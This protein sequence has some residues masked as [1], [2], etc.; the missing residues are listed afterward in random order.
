[1]A[2][3]SSY[4]SH[5]AGAPADPPEPVH[6]RVLEMALRARARQA[7]AAVDTVAPWRDAY[8]IDQ[9]GAEADAANP[10]RNK[11]SDGTIGD[12]AHAA[13][14]KGSDHNPWVISGGEGIV[15]ARD[16]TNDPALN[17]PA[18]AERIRAAA[19]A[20]KLPQVTGGG[21]VILN[22]R[23]TNENWSGWHEYTGPDPHVSHMHVSVSLAEKQFD[24][25]A[26]W[27]VFTAPQPP[28]P[29]NPQPPAPAAWT[30]PDATGSGP[31]FRAQFVPAPQ[32]NGPRVQAFQAFIRR[33]AP[34]Y[35]AELVVDGWYGQ[36]TAGVVAEF[37]RRCAIAGAD[38]NNIGPKI[39]FALYKAGFR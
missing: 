14:G 37:A 17:L 6:R 30:G 3:Q 22:G 29:V 2:E 35:A 5:Y 27:G 34:A 13:E 38:G 9:L 12:A 20:G 31:S 23:I 26:A 19:I 32:S 7:V 21:Y 10:S 25:R 15:R 33:Y 18:V 16:I 36:Q 1:M 4:P 8:A 39:A 24:S 28:A 11:A